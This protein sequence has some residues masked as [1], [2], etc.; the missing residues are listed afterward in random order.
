MTSSFTIGRLAAGA[1]VNV[2]TIR[3]YQRRGLLSEPARPA[4]GIRRYGGSHLARLQFI[5]RAQVVG[6]TLDEIADLLAVTGRQSC[7]E[8]RA[9]TCR[10]LVDIRHRMAQLQRLEADLEQLLAACDEAP[11]NTP[12]PALAWFGNEATSA[13]PLPSVHGGE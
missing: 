8:T 11:A 3:Y 6:F 13:S 1:D 4:G 5:R 12:C 9:L 10:K 2:E 7:A